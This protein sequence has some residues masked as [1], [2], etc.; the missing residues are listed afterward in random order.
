MRNHYRKLLVILLVLCISSIC[1]V[2]LMQNVSFGKGSDA[3]AAMSVAFDKKS[4]HSVDRIIIINGT[5]EIEVDDP[6]VISQVIEETTVATHM[7]VTCPIGRQINLYCGD[8]LIRSM[9][10]S[11]CCDTVNVYDTDITHW[12]V[13]VEGLEEGGSV[14]LSPGLVDTLSQ[15]M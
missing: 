5:T 13:S 7:K 10:W 12:V 4:I 9:G 2:L 11:R 15:Y 6:M 8:K 3:Y 1:M 14:Y